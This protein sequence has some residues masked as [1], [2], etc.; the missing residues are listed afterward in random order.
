V[1]SRDY[2][3][4]LKNRRSNVEADPFKRLV[5]IIQKNTK[6]IS[7]PKCHPG[8]LKFGAWVVVVAEIR[9]VSVKV[10]WRNEKI[11]IVFLDKSQLSH[12]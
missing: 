3:D 4:G 9:A 6:I 1:E 11:A 2:I 10:I 8:C 5:L 7:V 12:E